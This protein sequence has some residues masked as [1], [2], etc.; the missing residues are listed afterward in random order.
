VYINPA[1]VLVL[2]MESSQPI[3]LSNVFTDDYKYFE[4]NHTLFPH[5]AAT[6]FGCVAELRTALQAFREAVLFAKQFPAPAVNHTEDTGLVLSHDTEV[7][8]AEV[9]EPALLASVDGSV[10]EVAGAT[11]M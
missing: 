1:G 2:E 11:A 5:N 10:E 4:S 6:V 3:Q 9:A 7:V 8:C